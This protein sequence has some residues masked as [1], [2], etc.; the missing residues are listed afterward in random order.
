VRPTDP[1]VLLL[2]ASG[3]VGSDIR[4]RLCAAGVAVHAV[5]RRAPDAGIDTRWT[6][7]VEPAPRE[8]RR[9]WRCVIN[10]VAD[11]RWTMTPEEAKAA[12]VRTAEA[13]LEVADEATHVVHLSTSFIG[14]SGSPPPKIDLTAYRN[15]YEWSK[16]LSERAVLDAHPDATILRFP[17][18]VGRRTDGRLARFSGFFKVVG[19]VA[20][21]LLPAFVRAPG[22][23]LDVVAADDV[24]RMVASIVD[25]ALPRGRI[26]LGQG[27]AAPAVDHVL[28]VVLEGLDE[29]RL[30]NGLERLPHPP[31]VDHERWTRFFLPFARAELSPVHAKT[32]DVLGQF[33]PYLSI[34]E[35]VGVT[36]RVPPLDDAIRMTIACWAEAHRRVASSTPRAW[37]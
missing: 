33:L 20:T 35:P 5:G 3:A 7:G 10:A 15:T 18:V 2:G 36:W 28:D 29:W 31:R 16:A 30:A 12:N 34:T 11:T 1:D 32:L 6:L 22:G 26:V 25:G 23:I 8:L 17:I 14:G 13:L 27:D 4:E 9:S 24:S 37:R 19:A 21:G